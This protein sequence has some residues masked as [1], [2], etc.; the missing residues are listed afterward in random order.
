MKVTKKVRFDDIRT[1]VT[2]DFE[3]VL[4]QDQYMHARERNF[5]HQDSSLPDAPAPACGP[6]ARLMSRVTSEQDF[7]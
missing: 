6:E 4:D 2:Y 7:E 1:F 3:R 5:M